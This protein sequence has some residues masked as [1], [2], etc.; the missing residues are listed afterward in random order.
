LIA[1]IFQPSVPNYKDLLILSGLVPKMLLQDGIPFITIRNDT[2][3][4]VDALAVLWNLVF[5]GTKINLSVVGFKNLFCESIMIL[6]F[7][8]CVNQG[9]I[10]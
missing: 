3:G 6:Q 5:E 1:E 9:N 4:F 10:V 2:F 7:N 8:Y